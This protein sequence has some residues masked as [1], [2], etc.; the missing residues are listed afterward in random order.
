MLHGL[1]WDG[2][3]YG[4]HRMNGLAITIRGI[5]D[6]FLIKSGNLKKKQNKNKQITMDF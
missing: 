4:G 1:L 6:Q 3:K 2:N 5:F